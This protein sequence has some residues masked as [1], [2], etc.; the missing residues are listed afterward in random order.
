LA[1]R[2]YRSPRSSGSHA[3]VA[4]DD[5]LED[6][7][8]DRE[9]DDEEAKVDED[10]MHGKIISVFDKTSAMIGKDDNPSKNE[11]IDV[12]I[13]QPF[14]VGNFKHR[15]SVARSMFGENAATASSGKD[16]SD[17]SMISYEKLSTS[18]KQVFTQNRPRYYSDTSSITNLLKKDS[19]DG[20]NDGSVVSSSNDRL[21]AA[22]SL[23]SETPSVASKSTGMK[24]SKKGDSPESKHTIVSFDIS[25][26][27]SKGTEETSPPTPNRVKSAKSLILGN[28][29]EVDKI[30][31]AKNETDNDDD[32]DDNE[33]ESVD[34]N[35][36]PK[37]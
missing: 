10:R 36:E 22:R 35:E 7:S 27:A 16:K 20:K 23:L 3:R 37:K 5:D 2:R 12:A 28:T 4:E 19:P 9:Y 33:D 32:D 30:I 14:S 13:G 17:S 8:V 1:H 31:E 29:D 24:S 26:G 11:T 21:S 15:V 34:S 18:D 25:N 6:Y